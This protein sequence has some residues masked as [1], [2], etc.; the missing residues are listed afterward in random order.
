MP[1]TVTVFHDSAGTMISSARKGGCRPPS[2]CII[3]VLIFFLVFP[4]AAVGGSADTLGKK[5]PFRPGERLTYQ[6]TWNA[7]PAGDMTLEVLPPE[8]VGGVQA[9]H[10]AMVTTT[11]AVVDLVYTVRERQ[12]SYVDAAMTHS[13]LYTKRAEGEHPRDVVVNFDWVK[14]EATR[15]NFGEKMAPVRIAP[16][17]FDPL[18]LFYVIRLHNIGTNSVVEIPVTEGDN[19]IIARAVVAKRELIEI[20]GKKYDV[21]EVAPDME[22]LEREKVVKKSET[23]ELKIWFTADER[24]IPVRIQSKV[25]VGYFTFDLVSAKL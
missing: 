17:S 4:H 15:S 22:L 16:G 21:F 14:G 19:A 11:N 2:R 1:V 12:D 8:M 9:Y 18:A 10:F 13:I 20:E 7:I 3:P 6:A 23:E 24:K 5:L 25:K